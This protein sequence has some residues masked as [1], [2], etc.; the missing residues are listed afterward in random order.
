MAELYV[1]ATPIGNLNDLSPRMAQA[2]ADCHL[3]AAEDTRVTMKLLN[4][5]GLKKPLVSLNRHTEGQ[6]APGLVARMVEEDLTVCL[7]CDAGTPGIS[8]PGVPLVA[9]AIEAG[10]RVTPICGPSA[11]TAHLSACGFDNRSFGFYGFLPR[12]KG[13]LAAKLEQIGRTGLN[14]AV[15]YESPHRVIGLVEAIGAAYPQCRLSVAC[16]ISKR[17]EVILTGPWARVLEQ[18]QSN[19]NVE[20]GEY[21]LVVELPLASPRPEPAPL[22]PE[23]RILTAMLEGR[24]LDQAVQEAAEQGYP[25]NQLYRAKLKIRRFLEGMGG[26]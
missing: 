15:F 26:E 21:S 9:Q 8:D 24:D 18:L 1:V 17:Y 10:I 20:K 13:D 16:D 19:P 7:T 6:K 5:L 12:E 3:I 22:P 14:A 11:F 23:A 25:R 2:L 4:H